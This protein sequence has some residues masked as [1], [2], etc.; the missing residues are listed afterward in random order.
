MKQFRKML[1]VSNGLSNDVAA[2]QQAI[3]LAAGNRASL[4]IMLNCPPFNAQLKEYQSSYEDFLRGEMQ[5]V[6]DKVF[7]S[8]SLQEKMIIPI[9][10]EWGT[11]PHIHIIQRVIR[12]SYDLVIKDVEQSENKGF[13]ALDMSLLRKCPCEVFLCRPSV[14]VKPLHIAVAID[15]S[16]EDVPAHELAVRLLQLADELKASYQGKISIVSC[17]DL[18]LENFLRRSAFVDLS[19]DQIDEMVLQESNNHYQLLNGLIHE[20]VM[21]EAP[22]IYHLQGAPIEL[23]PAFIDDEKV[24]IL[25]MGTVARTGLAGFIMGNTAE[26]ILQKISCSLWAMKPN[27]FVSPVKAY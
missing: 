24:D 14:A 25:V 21:Q 6:V 12:F 8:L 23:I 16:D 5:K 18:A 26:N 19:N 17:W 3:R 2:L 10:I 22:K 11:T 27:G 15:P 4:D 9:D 1:F 20:A 7:A 13:K